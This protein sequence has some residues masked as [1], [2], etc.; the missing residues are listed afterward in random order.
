MLF[1]LLELSSISIYKVKFSFRS[2]SQKLSLVYPHM[3]SEVPVRCRNI[4]MERLSALKLVLRCQTPYLPVVYST[5]AKLI[6]ILGVKSDFIEN[7][8]ESLLDGLLV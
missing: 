2:T 1:H 8:S 6:I 7:V 5:S 4:L 3:V